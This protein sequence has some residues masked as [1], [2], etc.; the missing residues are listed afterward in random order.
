MKR[1]SSVI[2][3][4]VKELRS[5]LKEQPEV[6]RERHQKLLMHKFQV[7]LKWK[8]VPNALGHI[9]T[10]VFKENIRN[11]FE[12]L[13]LIDRE[14]EKLWNEFNVQNECEETVKD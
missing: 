9:L 12:V 7:R 8:F 5:R 14:P 4:S 1:K 6:Y 11:P 3:S 10:V 2:Y 13:D